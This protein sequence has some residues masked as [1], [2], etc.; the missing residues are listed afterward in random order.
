MIYYRPIGVDVVADPKL[1][2]LH[3]NSKSS[4]VPYEG[5]SNERCER[6]KI[7]VAASRNPNKQ[8]ERLTDKFDENPA[9]N[10]KQISNMQ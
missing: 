2:S 10:V 7:N 1:V 4:I 5:Y 3:C 8:Y 6:L 9:R